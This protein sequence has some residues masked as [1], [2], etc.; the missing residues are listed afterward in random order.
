MIPKWL[1]PAAAY[2]FL[3]ILMMFAGGKAEQP[4]PQE[5]GEL[6]AEELKATERIELA[7]DL[8]EFDLRT[9][10]GQRLGE[11]EELVVDVASGHVVFLV[12]RIE[13]KLTPIPVSFLLLDRISNDFLVDLQDLDTLE[14]APSFESLRLSESGGLAGF[15]NNIFRY[16]SA[17][18]INPPY[19]LSEKIPRRGRAVRAYGPG[20][21]YLPGSLISFSTLRDKV[22][23][24]ADSARAGM[25]EDLIVFP[26]TGRIAAV[27]FSQTA[28]RPETL[29]PL[30]VSA[31][32]WNFE[33]D[34]LVVDVSAESFQGAP[35]F[36]ASALERQL[37]RGD[38]QEQYR[39]Y[40]IE[41]EPAVGF[42]SGMRVVPGAAVRST[43][44]LGLQV[45]NWNGE[46]LGTIR[47]AVL[48]S[49]GSMPYVMVEFTGDLLEGVQQ[50][51]YPIPTEAFTVEFFRGVAVLGFP[52]ARLRELPGFPVG[53][54]PEVE[55]SRWQAQVRSHWEKLLKR[56]PGSEAEGP[57]SVRQEQQA[58]LVLLTELL[59]YRARNYEGQNLGRI[60]ELVVNLQAGR[61]DYIALEV[62]AT[63]GVGGK[64]VAVP[65][66]SVELNTA[67]RI[68]RVEAE[69]A[70]LQRA[71]GFDPDNWPSL[72]GP[73][74][75]AEIRSFS[76]D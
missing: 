44:M 37:G 58:Q 53:S 65:F 26:G 67:D 12:F 10:D 49:D 23:R 29:Y 20:V 38:W 15:T 28:G 9:Y 39:A 55:D 75:E 16:W 21:R 76:V 40:W 45:S 72:S 52:R 56:V 61:A 43:R 48:R 8:M 69:P 14:R 36:R 74:W 34:E 18:G 4:R 42:R 70:A 7:T 51:W 54:I 24:H 31:F 3:S 5:T 27:L 2:L 19:L 13:D 35:T 63:A 64:L 46:S 30:P 68:L 41:A 25:V 17:V 47:D 60:E 62:G 66:E 1:L 57:E 11:V 73:G 6:K 50:K 59:E 33:R 71:P 32:T 22:V